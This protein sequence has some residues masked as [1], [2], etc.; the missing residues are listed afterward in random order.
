MTD[1]WDF[2]PRTIAIAVTL[3]VL[4]VAV[5]SAKAAVEAS[6]AAVR[7]AKIAEDEA[8]LRRRPWVGVTVIELNP[9]SREGFTDAITIGYSNFGALVAQELEFE[10][11]MSPEEIAPGDPVDTWGSIDTSLSEGPAMTF[12]ASAGS[13]FP[14][15]QDS[16]IKLIESLSLFHEWRR[17]GFPIVF[18]GRISYRGESDSY[19]TDF[20]GRIEF[21]D[22][23]GPTV[24][25]GN[26]TLG[27]NHERSHPQ[28]GQPLRCYTSC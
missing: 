14:H 19:Y 7:T 26:T 27:T 22:Q 3:L 20:K 13:V 4:V 25:Y 5:I 28:P 15:Q 6:R 8:R 11:T 21:V 24:S 18:W 17:T 16:F 10:L 9:S 12:S 1:G 23:G 2:N